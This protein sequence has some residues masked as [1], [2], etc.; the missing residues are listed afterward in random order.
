MR[1]FYAMVTLGHGM[2]YT[3]PNGSLK[4]KLCGQG[5]VLCRKCELVHA[6]RSDC[7]I[8]V[9]CGFAEQAI[10]AG[11]QHHRPFFVLPVLSLRIGV[12]RFWQLACFIV[13]SVVCLDQLFPLLRCHPRS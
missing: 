8:H 13:L 2:S 11:D 6:R 7:H 9:Q 3:I 12:G 1:V 5:R 4:L 10:R